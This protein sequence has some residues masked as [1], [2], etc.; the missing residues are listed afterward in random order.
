MLKEAERKLDLNPF[1][2]RSRSVIEKEEVDLHSLP[3]G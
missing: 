1:L 3:G 2:R